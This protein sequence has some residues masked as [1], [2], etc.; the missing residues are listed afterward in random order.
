MHWNLGARKWQ[1][2]LAETQ[3]LVN[4]YKP[5]FCFLS[6]ANIATNLPVHQTIIHGYTLHTPKSHTNYNLSRLVLLAKEGIKFKIEWNRMCPEV[7]SIW[8]SVGGKGR[9]STLIG[10]M[11]REFTQLHEGAPI[12][13]GDMVSQKM[14]WKKF[15]N[16][17]KQA[18]EI[19]SCW[20]IGDLNLDV[21]KWNEQNYENV[22]LVNLVKDEI[23]T[24]NFSQLIRKPTRFW[25]GSTSLLD[26]IW[27]NCPEKQLNVRNVDRAS[28]DHNMISTKIR[29]KGVEKSQ[30]EL[31]ARDKKNFVEKDFKQAISMIDW[32]SLYQQEDLNLANDLF[33]TK[34]GNILNEMAP[35]KKIQ[36]RN[37]VTPW[38]TSVT[39]DL[40]KDRDKA[41]NLASE[42]NL[43]DNWSKYRKLRNLCTAEVKKDKNKFLENQYKKYE[44]EN[45]L[46]IKYSQ[47]KKNMGWTKTGPPTAFRTEKGIEKKPKILADMQND[48]YTEKKKKL[49]N[50]LPV[51]NEDPLKILKN[52]LTRWGEKNKK[53]KKNE[54]PKSKCQSHKKYPKKTRQ[55]YLF[56]TR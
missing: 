6:E 11:Y 32:T 19:S 18:S 13:S 34:I 8:I 15:I 36:L 1:N 27:T 47:V 7:A 24:E 41:R 5:D 40:M 53:N 45:D 26:H 12:N 3:A 28:S 25:T 31:F 2:K 29:V 37:R 56:W 4:E 9:K 16:Q 21:L 38:V 43:Q 49:E 17:W 20:I 50:S 42:T 48:F 46:K 39:K 35:M 22:D 30:N 14:R 10:G 51:T 23:E 55:Q 52:A 33:A 44:N 54:N